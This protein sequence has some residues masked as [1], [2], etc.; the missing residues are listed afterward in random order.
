MNADLA[1]VRLQSDLNA[2]LD[3]LANEMTGARLDNDWSTYVALKQKREGM[4]LASH[5]L[6]RHIMRNLDE[7]A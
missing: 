3:E 6:H 7:V 5:L 1:L 4:L 2:M